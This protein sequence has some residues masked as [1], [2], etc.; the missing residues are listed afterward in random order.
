MRYEYHFEYYTSQDDMTAALDKLG[1][2]GYRLASIVPIV[3][4][5][6]ADSFFVTMERAI[7]VDKG[8]DTRP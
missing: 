6:A 5:G 7:P 3:S 2:Q 4:E 8:V 1:E